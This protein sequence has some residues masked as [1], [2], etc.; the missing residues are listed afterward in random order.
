MVALL[1]NAEAFRYVL[2]IKVKIM[3]CVKFGRTSRDR[4]KPFR[5]LRFE[6]FKSKLLCFIIFF[7]DA[8]FFYKPCD[9]KMQSE[10]QF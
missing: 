3:C 7:L 2:V 1:L 6:I 5:I 10:M 9:L 4:K 8:I